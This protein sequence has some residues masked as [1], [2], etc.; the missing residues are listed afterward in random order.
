MKKI[1]MMGTVLMGTVLG[2]EIV[3]AV[4][5]ESATKATS[6]GQIVVLENDDNNHIPDP[7]DPDKPVEPEVPVNPNPGQLKI[8]YVS[9]FDF[10]NQKNTSQAVSINAEL[11]TLFDANG[12]ELHR[13][14]FIATEDLRG[15]ERT[16]WEL[17]VSQPTNFMDSNGNELAGATISL[18]NLHYTNEINTPTVT[19]GE[20]VINQEEQTIVRA[21]KTQGMGAWSL[22]L[23]KANNEGKTDGVTLNIP[24]NTTKNNTTYKTSIV[25]ELIAEPTN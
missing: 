8:N 20:L 15:T 22:A 24:A 11:D 23:G 1:V 25:W 6:N 2:G 21:D 5:Y 13:V 16:G 17:R 14:P 18:N 4:D 7:E 3:R 9:D 12:E 10:G 19:N